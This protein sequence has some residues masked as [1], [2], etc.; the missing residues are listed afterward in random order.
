MEFND[1]R[2]ATN[3]EE[4]AEFYDGAQVLYYDLMGL[5]PRGR[6]VEHFYHIGPYFAKSHIGYKD[7]EIIATAPDFGF[8][9][10]EQ[11]YYGVSTDGHKFDF[12]FRYTGLLKKRDGVWR[13][14]QEHVSFPANIATQMADFTCSQDAGEHLRM[15]DEDNKKREELDKAQA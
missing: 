5:I 3:P 9:N 8:C 13:W 12:K 4:G 15:K 7:M 10:M 2:F 11:H 14:I 6:F 1:H